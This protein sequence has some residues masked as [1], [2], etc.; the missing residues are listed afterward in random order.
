MSHPPGLQLLILLVPHSPSASHNDP[1]GTLLQFG[2]F[3]FDGQAE[4]AIAV[5]HMLQDAPAWHTAFSP[6]QANQS[7]TDARHL[8]PKRSRAP[9]PQHRARG[10]DPGLREVAGQSDRWP[11]G[12]APSTPRRGGGVAGSPWVLR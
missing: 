10:G 8:P 6:A 4:E 11:E 5:R 1:N 7:Q 3:A 9:V 2:R 12:Q